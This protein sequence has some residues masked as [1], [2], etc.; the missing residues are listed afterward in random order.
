MTKPQAL[1]LL[2]SGYFNLT[3]L[4]KDMYKDEADANAK[5]MRLTWKIKQKSI[6]EVEIKFLEKLFKT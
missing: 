5:R 1:L 6:G 4:A 2:N 3:A